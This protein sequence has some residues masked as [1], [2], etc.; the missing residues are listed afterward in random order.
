MPRVYHRLSER[1]SPGD[2]KKLAG[3]ALE[4]LDKFV[5][6]H[7]RW[8]LYRR[9][10][11]CIA[12]CQGAALHYLNQETGIKDFD[13]WIF[14]KA[15]PD[16]KPFPY[17][18]VSHADFGRSRFGKWSA[19]KGY[20]GRRVDLIGRTLDTRRRDPVLALQDYLD[21]RKS[22]SARCLAE[23]A[24]VVIYPLSLLG[25]VAWSPSTKE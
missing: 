4:D 2:L 5:K 20:V 17:R 10:I 12:L 14:F 11:L 7:S 8:Q 1:D 23:K 9:R 16:L 15:S 24:A 22:R 18:R 19:D 25:T 6:D 13:V 3:L 21:G